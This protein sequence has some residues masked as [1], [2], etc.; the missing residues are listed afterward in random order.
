MP[1]PRLSMQLI[2]EILRLSLQ[3]KLS[4]NEIHDVVGVSR[5]K[6]QDCI[7]KASAAGLTWP[8]PTNDSD[9]EALLNPP[10]VEAVEGIPLPNWQKIHAELRRKGTTSKLLWE[11]YAREHPKGYGYSQFCRLY[12]RWFLQQDLV[13]RQEHRAGEKLFV[14]FVGLKVP[15]VCRHTG[16]VTMASVF[17]AVFGASNYCYAEACETEELRNWLAA[18]VRAFRFFGGVPK[19]V[20]PDNL[21]SAVIEAKRY[22]PILNK[23]FLRLAQHYGFGILPARPYRPKDKANVSYCMSSRRSN[24]TSKLFLSA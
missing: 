5:G 20:V 23:S 16:E 13:M 10:S 21:K 7:R 12:R 6:V 22:D 15:I 11:E 8:L 4:A 18:H 1:R 14:D 24:H 17:A 2:R 19:Y 3:L 9:L